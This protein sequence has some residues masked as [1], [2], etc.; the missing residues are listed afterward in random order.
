METTKIFWSGRS[1]AVLLPKEFRF[2]GDSVAI[3]RQGRAIILEPISD[4]WDWLVDVAGP[5]DPDFATAVEEQP[6]GQE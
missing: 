5:V 6:A 1:Q 2:D 3:R 4:D